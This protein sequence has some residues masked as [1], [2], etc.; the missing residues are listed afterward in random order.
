MNIV[1]MVRATPIVIDAHRIRHFLFS[2]Y[3]W[4]S[5]SS[6]LQMVSY[7]PRFLEG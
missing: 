6:L 3:C 2:L 1:T 4:D 5:H 7:G